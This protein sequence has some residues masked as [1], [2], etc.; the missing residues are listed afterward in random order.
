MDH[1]HCGSAGR[2][3]ELELLVRMVFGVLRQRRKHVFARDHEP[4][5]DL[6]E[7]L[8]EEKVE[9]KEQSSLIRPSADS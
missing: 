4:A 9:E 7:K 2:P 5:H 8:F 1:I 3:V 6:A